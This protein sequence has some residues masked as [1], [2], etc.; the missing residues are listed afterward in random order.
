MTGQGFEGGNL[1]YGWAVRNSV[2]NANGPED[3]PVALYDRGPGI[4][5]DFRIAQ[6][7]RVIGKARVLR[8]V[9]DDQGARGAQGMR[10]EALR[11]GS[12]PY[13][14]HAD[15]RFEP[16]AIAI[17]ERHQRHGRIADQRSEGRDVFV[18]LLGQGVE[19]GV[20]LQGLEAS[21]LGGDGRGFCHGQEFYMCPGE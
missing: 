15:D 11:T 17:D 16:L 19:D 5:P 20:E 2:D 4:K 21:L 6:N 9:F 3:M 12:L 7:G 13:F 14:A 10:A 8:G 1:D 18:Y